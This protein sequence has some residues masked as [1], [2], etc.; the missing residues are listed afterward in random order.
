MVKAV[1]G[2]SGPFAAKRVAIGGLFHAVDIVWHIL[3]ERP[4]RDYMQLVRQFSLEG[5][6]ATSRCYRLPIK[7]PYAQS[8]RG[9]GSVKLFYM[10]YYSFRKK[11]TLP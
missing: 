10:F 7:H 8:M 11:M 4:S 5:Q 1:R 3:L 2:S 9:N 6:D